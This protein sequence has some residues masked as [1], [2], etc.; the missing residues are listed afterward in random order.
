MSHPHFRL[1]RLPP[2]SILRNCG[3]KSLASDF[4]GRR[5]RIP[6]YAP[7]IRRHESPPRSGC[8]HSDWPSSI[9]RPSQF[10]HGCSTYQSGICAEIQWRRILVSAF[11]ASRLSTRI[12]PRPDDE[13]R[14]KIVR[15]GV[16]L[17]G[18]DDIDQV[19]LFAGVGVLQGSGELTG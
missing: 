9:S 10:H 18:T 16:T 4:H 19:P 6:C 12:P 2:R 1:H 11:P 7:R 3:A 14:K 13:E 8:R 17:I 15:A 5:Q